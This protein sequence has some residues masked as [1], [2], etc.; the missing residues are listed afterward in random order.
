MSNIIRTVLK[1]DD[2][3]DNRIDIKKEKEKQEKEKKDKEKKDLEEKEKKE[4]EKEKKEK[5]NNDMKDAWNLKRCK[6]IL[7]IKK[8]KK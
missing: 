2:L 5:A 3:L 8:Y 7:L 1:V 4:A 6:S